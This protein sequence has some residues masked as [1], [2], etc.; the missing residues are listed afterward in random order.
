MYSHL[1]DSEQHMLIT[2]SIILGGVR[3]VPS[4]TTNLLDSDA[5]QMQMSKS[6][7]ALKS[8]QHFISSQGAI[9]RPV[10]GRGI[11]AQFVG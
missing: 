5:R 10:E 2:D 6:D 8:R 9:S 4:R 7:A 11:W 1:L 3:G